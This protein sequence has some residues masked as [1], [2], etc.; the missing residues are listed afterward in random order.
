MVGLTCRYALHRVIP[1]K[2]VSVFD[3]DQLERKYL[4]VSWS[5]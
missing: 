4:E 1:R 2:L 5:E 3:P